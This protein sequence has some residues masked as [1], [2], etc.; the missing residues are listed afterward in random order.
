MDGIITQE[1]TN[2]L[3][4][5]DDEQDIDPMNHKPT[6]EVIRVCRITCG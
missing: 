2:D 4:G 1:E 3:L 5:I 6:Y